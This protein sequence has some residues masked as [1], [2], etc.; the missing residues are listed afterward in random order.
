MAA[1]IDDADWLRALKARRKMLASQIA[2]LQKELKHLE[3]LEAA[4]TQSPAK[5]A[6]QPKRKPQPLKRGEFRNKIR[7]VMQRADKPLRPAE[8]TQILKD[9]GFQNPGTGDFNSRIATELYKL[10]QSGELKKVPEGY[11][12][13]PRLV[14][15]SA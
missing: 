13:S 10:G 7:E 2:G 14:V 12:V 6:Q 11:V 1:H 4:A 8:V 5:E 3:D 15:K 9:N